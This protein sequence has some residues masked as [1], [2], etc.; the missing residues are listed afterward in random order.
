MYCCLKAYE[1]QFAE[2]NSIINGQVYDL[3]RTVANK[4]LMHSGMMVECEISKS[5]MN[6]S[7]GSLLS[8]S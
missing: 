8:S 6:Q 4:P 2:F 3:D 5:P 1:A 7:S